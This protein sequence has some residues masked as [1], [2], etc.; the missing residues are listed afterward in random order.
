[1]NVKSHLR[2]MAVTT[3]PLMGLALGSP[4]VSAYSGSAAAAYADKYANHAN[5][6]QYPVFSD[7]CT[8]F[9]SQ[10]VHA[11]GYSMVGGSSDTN[12]TQWWIK[13]D[14]WSWYGY[15]WSHSWAIANDYN[16][17]LNWD[18][19]GGIDYGTVDGGDSNYSDGLSQGDVL[20]YDWNNS[21]AWNHATMQVAYG[22]DPASGWYG[23]LVD[24]H[25]TNRYHAFWSL[26]PYNSQWQT[27]T[28]DLMHISSYNS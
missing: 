9:V 25:T 14:F 7:D 1:M 19:P 23:D 6:S 24:E 22:T 16:T 10:A 12:D 2:K 26:M 4:V 21:N 11:G 18:S 13:P 8:N 3:V 5:S 17:F 20:F 15:D 27:T 28:I